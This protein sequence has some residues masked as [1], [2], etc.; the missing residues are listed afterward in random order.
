[1]N[2]SNDVE[3]LTKEEVHE[4]EGLCTQVTS[5]CGEATKALAALNPD[6]DAFDELKE[7]L[8]PQKFTHSI[9]RI[10]DFENTDRDWVIRA[11]NPLLNQRMLNAF[12]LCRNLHTDISRKLNNPVTQH[13]ERLR[14]PEQGAPGQ[15]NPGYGYGGAGHSSGLSNVHL[16]RLVGQQVQ[17]GTAIDWTPTA[18][19][20]QRRDKNIVTE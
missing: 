12:Q 19:A 15:Q 9:K 2:R 18:H 11:Q 8:D 16:A 3:P 20:K 17:R 10:L 6:K 4:I 14:T 7:A 5:K 13:V 1:M